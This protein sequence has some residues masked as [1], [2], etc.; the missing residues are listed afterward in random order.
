[1]TLNQN[2]VKNIVK[3]V[4][5]SQD[6]RDEIVYLINEEFLQCAIDFFKRVV[7]AK[8]EAKDI[9]IDWYKNAFMNQELKSDEIALNSG[10]NKKTISNMRGS[11]RRE[12]VIDASNQHFEALYDSIK[13]LVEAEPDLDL[14]LTI[15]L[16]DVSV[17]LNVSESLI[18]INT[19]AV[20]RAAIRGGYWST[21]G[22][23]AEKAIMLALCKLFK[24]SE[25]NYNAEHF[26]KNRE[27]DFDR[28]IDFYL[29]TPSKQYQCE[30]KLMGKGNPESADA[31]IARGSELFVADTLSVQN[32]NQCN[33]LGVSWVALRDE[34]GYKRFADALDKFGI[35]Y[36]KYNGDLNE[37]L[38]KVLDE[39]F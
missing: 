2:I 11:A 10:L 33:S 37:D 14:K 13:A 8:L 35:P 1:M 5:M 19:L 25:S 34:N 16:R 3:K 36:T 28:E 22:K 23:Q 9:T 12:V 15:K 7:E 6:Y 31:I 30:V 39:I 27:I 32:K 26:V 18:V 17:D 4:I 29:K 24:V 38:P 21:A 20:K